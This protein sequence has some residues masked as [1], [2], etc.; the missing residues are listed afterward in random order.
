MPM[1]DGITARPQPWKTEL[2]CRPMGL[3]TFGQP[4]DEQTGAILIVDGGSVHGGQPVEA[5]HDIT[6][7]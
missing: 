3:E 4:V 7:V 1:A 2:S 6:L 5:A